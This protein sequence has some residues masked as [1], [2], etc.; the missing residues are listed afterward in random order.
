MFSP[1]AGIVFAKRPDAFPEGFL[2]DRAK[3]YGRNIDPAA[4]MMAVP[5]LLDQLRAHFD[6]LNQLIDERSFLQGTAASLADLAAYHRIWFLKQKF[7]PSS[8]PLGRFPNL[9]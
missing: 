1:V 2:E 8:V 5:N 6:W 9:L 7:C 3:F 4:M